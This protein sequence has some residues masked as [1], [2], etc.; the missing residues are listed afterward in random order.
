M[1]ESKNL[2]NK[3]RRGTASLYDIL[4]ELKLSENVFKFVAVEKENLTKINKEIEEHFKNDVQDFIKKI[5][6]VY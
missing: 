2:F 4:K 6:N 3:N 5:K 1:L